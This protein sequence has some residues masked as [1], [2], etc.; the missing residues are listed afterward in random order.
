MEHGI[1]SRITAETTSGHPGESGT[2]AAAILQEQDWT[3][4]LSIHIRQAFT[5]IGRRFWRNDAGLNRK[6]RMDQSAVCADLLV[7]EWIGTVSAAGAGT[8]INEK[9]NTEKETKQEID[10]AGRNWN[11]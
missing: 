2:L 1:A 10:I 5:S 11:N 8:R 6:Q 7:R 3:T 4:A 9:A